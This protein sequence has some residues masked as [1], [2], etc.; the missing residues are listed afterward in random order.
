MICSREEEKRMKKT[1]LCNCKSCRTGGCSICRDALYQAQDDKEYEK[2][3]VLD[4]GLIQSEQ[5]IMKLNII[6]WRRHRP[7]SDPQA[8]L[9]TIFSWFDHV[10]H[11][12]IFETDMD[13]SPKRDDFPGWDHV[14]DH[15]AYGEMYWNWFHYW[16]GEYGELHFSDAPDFY[17]S[18]KFPD[19]TQHFWGDVGQCSVQA[20]SHAQKQMSEGDLWIS[21]RGTKKQVVIESHLDILNFSAKL[22]RGEHLPI[23]EELEPQTSEHIQLK[24]F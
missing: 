20:F 9:H 19:K 24:L 12:T 2:M 8:A 11:Y 17:G 7:W 23:I 21:I 22:F 15:E 3:K 14:G 16:H 1:T 5:D 4:H 6:D 10:A 18:F 13:A